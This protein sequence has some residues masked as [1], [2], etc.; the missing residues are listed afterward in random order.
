[1]TSFL[2]IG[3]KIIDEI[4]SILQS[5]KVKNISKHITGGIKDLAI[6][7]KDNTN[8]F[9]RK[10]NSHKE[11]FNCHKL[12]CFFRRDYPHFDKRF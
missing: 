7:F 3:N 1:M 2:E 9:K 12:G 6:V 5:K 8:L 10:A 4:Q 11:C